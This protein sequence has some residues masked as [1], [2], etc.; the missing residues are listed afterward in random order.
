MGVKA[1]GARV[2]R[3]ED[4]A[5]L[6]G[7]GRFVDDIVPPGALHA[8]FVRS[9][10][11]HARIRAIQTDAALAMPGVH[12]VL[13][14][15]DLPAPMN[16]ERIP[17]LMPNPA[18]RIMRTQHALAVEEV[19]FVG[20]AVAMVIADDRYLA[21]DAAALVEVD[22]EALPVA[23]DPRDSIK[24]G[25]SPAH[26]DLP[27]NIACDLT[28][29]H[30]DIDAAFAAAA[31]VI[32]ETFW[33]HRGSGMPMET[34]AVVAQADPVT[35]L[36]TVW[37]ATQTPH[38]GRRILADMLDR[39]SESIR[40]IAPDVGGGFGLKAPFY[41]E[42][43]AVP[44]AALILGRPVKWS[45]DR[46]ENFLA[47]AQERDQHWTLAVALDGDGKILGVR[48]A[49]LQD[50][51]A[52][53]PWGMVLPYI[54]AVTVPG[55]YVVPNYR[56]QMTVAV[57]NKPPIAPVRGAGRPQAV[58][59]IERLMDRAAQTLSL[60]P[61]ELRRRNLIQPEQMPY[62]VGLV[63]QDRRPMT[64]HGGDYPASQAKAMEAAG[65]A[66]FAAR[67]AEARKQGRFIG[68]GLANYVEGTGLGPFEGATVRVLQNGKVAVSTG[69][70]SQGQGTLTSLMQ[71]VAERIG[72]DMD[73]VVVT[74]ADT[75]SFSL[76][77][78]AF[79]SRQA[80]TAGSATHTAALAVR[81]KI[82][83]MAS[84]ALG[85]PADDI[86]V[87]NGR[88]T[89]RSGN[90]PS[91]GFGELARMAQG[92]PGVSFPDGQT[93][94]L[95][96]TSFYH[97]PSYSYCN[98]THIAEVEV[99]PMTGGVAVTRY[100]IAHDSGTLINPM[101][102]DGQVQGGTA[103]GIGNALFEHMRFDADGNPLTTTF[104]DYLLPTAP[105]VPMC[106]IVHIETPNP[107]NPLG[108]K[109]AG[110][111]GAIPSPAAVVSAIENALSPFGVRL[112][113]MP[114]TPGKIV[115]ALREAG[116]YD[117]LTAA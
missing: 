116:A 108:V 74:L 95:E 42:E 37:S 15:A 83:S 47:A 67:Q 91:I 30:G 45:E 80:I 90:K 33:M 26:S 105:E 12:A 21:E 50:S 46:R 4:P 86:D 111:G 22:Y 109:G 58:F 85:V 3:F 71:V 55:P 10:L 62:E 73:D 34:R 14:A 49:L 72:C 114:L 77:I 48:G 97:P 89:A 40:M 41:P 35:G 98:G 101:I 13:T 82:V 104:Q 69:A 9:P 44:A 16:R 36:L 96:E 31:H 59:A 38:L 18:I 27:D 60:D 54:A 39:D 56:M 20:E 94:G 25:A 117:T 78:G 84:R 103:H 66:G 115:A 79:A 1:F 2:T 5:L 8:C 87:E 81:A 63:G 75:G 64:Y 106:R 6:S 112:N 23:E 43:A 17:N 100:T 53:M 32:E 76:G 19:C 92:A 24:P 70:T 102:V 68:I 113:E 51:G 57:N 52:F 110:E 61:A 7:R 11:A 88:A 99:D 65:Y 93:A 107:L 29:G 28:M